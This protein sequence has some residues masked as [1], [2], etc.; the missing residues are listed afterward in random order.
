[1]VFF[2]SFVVSLTL[3]WTLKERTKTKPNKR[4]RE[5]QEITRNFLLSKEQKDSLT[6]RRYVELRSLQASFLPLLLTRVCSFSTQRRGE[7]TNKNEGKLEKKRVLFGSC[8]LVLSFVRCRVRRRS[9]C[10]VCACL[11]SCASPRV[12]TYLYFMFCV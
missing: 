2:L 6:R 8:V 3:Y 9:F 1:M 12:C 5:D 7:K 4:K 10:D 11:C